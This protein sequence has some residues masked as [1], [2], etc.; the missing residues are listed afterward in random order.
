VC[1]LSQLL[2]TP[3]GK[4]PGRARAVKLLLDAMLSPDIADV[5]GL[6]FVARR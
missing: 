2:L 4:R 3:R 5:S 6:T 1:A